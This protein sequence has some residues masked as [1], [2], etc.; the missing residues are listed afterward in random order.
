MCIYFKNRARACQLRPRIFYLLA[1]KRDEWLR[2]RQ[3]DTTGPGN[4]IEPNELKRFQNHHAVI[5]REKL[6]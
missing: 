3:D 1:R 6:K 4:L 2:S 5:F